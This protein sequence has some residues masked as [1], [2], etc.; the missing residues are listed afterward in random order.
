MNNYNEQEDKII[1]CYS[2][3]EKDKIYSSTQISKKEKAR[4]KDCVLNEIKTRHAHYM[5]LCE[6]DHIGMLDLMHTNKKLIYYIE[7][8][9]LQKVNELLQKDNINPNYMRQDYFFDIKKG[10]WLRWYN[11]D[12]NEKP[13]TDPIQPNTP[14]KLCIFTQSNIL[15]SITEKHIIIEIAKSL[16]SVGAIVDD[17][18]IN[19]FTDRY[20][21]K[22]YNHII[23]ETFYELLIQ[24]KK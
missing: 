7:N 8:M 9:D 1:Y 21:E 13:D 24:N 14:L 19:Y 16:I 12:D 15:F 22:P 3:G 10:I 6:G 17:H 18:V 2:C 23:F 11:E 4:C 20:G 5:Y